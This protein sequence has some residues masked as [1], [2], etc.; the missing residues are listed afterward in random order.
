M[1]SLRIFD[2]I[3]NDFKYAT[4]LL[5][6][7][8]IFTGM[9][10]LIMAVG[11]G[12][13]LFLFSFFHTTND[14]PLPFP[15]SQSLVI[16]NSFQQGVQDYGNEIDLHDYLEIRNNIKGLTEFGAY[17]S[18]QLN[19][20]GKDGS[21]R[22]NGIMMEPNLFQ[23]TRTKPVLGREFNHSDNLH[24][25][26]NVVIIGHDMWQNQFAGSA[27]VIE[28]N[29]R[30]NGENHQIIGVMPAGYYFPARAEMWLPMRQDANQLRRGQGNSYYGIAHIEKGYSMQDINQQLAVIMKRLE[31]KYPK[32]N[33]SISAFVSTLQKGQGTRGSQKVIYS[34]YIVAILIL[35]LASINVGNLLLARAVQ[36]AKETAIRV[37]LG[38]PQL[39]IVTQMMWESIIIC[40]LGGVIGLL[41]TAWG[42]EILQSIVATFWFDKPVFWWKFSIDGYTTKIVLL[43][44]SITILL[45]GLIPAWK[46]SKINVNLALRD[47]T[48]GAQGKKAGWL[49]RILVVSEIFLSTTVMIAA[50]II[51]VVNYQATQADYGAKPDNLLIAQLHLPESTY[52]NPEQRIQL[53]NKLQSRLEE[54]HEIGELMIL[55]ALPGARAPSAK[56]A[57][58]GTEYS[59]QGEQDYPS[60]NY[61]KVTPG[62]L[63]KLGV[64]LKQ[65]RYFNPGDNVLNKHSVIVTTS[66]VNRYM[67]AISPIGKRIRLINHNDEQNNWLL[68]VGVVEHTIQGTA[69]SQQGQFP[70]IFRPFSQDPDNQLS[71]A[72]KIKSTESSTTLQLRE[73]LKSI[74]PEL[75]A[76]RIETY[77]SMIERNTAALTFISTLLLLFG[78]VAIFF[79]GSGIYGLMSNTINQRTQEFGVKRALGANE[80]TITRELLYSGLKQLFW[81]GISGLIAGSAMGFAMSRVLGNISMT[82][83]IIIALS[84]FMI[85]ACVVIFATFVPT[86]RVLQM[87]PAEALHYE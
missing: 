13:S 25:A 82:L 71:L 41:M 69:T 50:S 10:V 72:M 87:E 19:V 85:V 27:R 21:R 39:R 17:R 26:K 3:T 4:R 40:S 35:L 14:K 54:S 49:N 5:L 37:A 86:R 43:F 57:L 77:T 31:Q 46:N 47:G 20:S 78:I 34:M 38:A 74:D 66:F 67:P 64:S 80:H 68:I 30:I 45:T 53:V 70:S 7:T 73:V 60:T 6:K 75:P 42:L 28:E 81:G 22:Y 79:A 58:E 23:I 8:P 36:R 24:G 29:L 52:T 15:D 83:L 62:S 32:S 65:G 55:T 63:E 51:V 1:T 11:I 18:E 59:Q 61:I 2:L 9:T 84:I 56:I 44:T 48:R 16:L 76:Y 12:L 33:Y